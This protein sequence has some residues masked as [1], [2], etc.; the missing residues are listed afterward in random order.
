MEHA[1]SNCGTLFVLGDGTLP[2]CRSCIRSRFRHPKGIKPE[3][4]PCGAVGSKGFKSYIGD[5][6]DADQLLDYMASGSHTSPSGCQVFISKTHGSFN[7]VSYLPL[8]QIPGSGYKAGHHFAAHFAILMDLQGKSADGP[9]WSFEEEAHLQ[10][11]ITKGDFV[12]A[13]RCA[14]CRTVVVYAPEI[15][16]LN[17]R[18]KIA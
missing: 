7:A 9:H 1:C 12:P 11:R 2:E 10:L 6:V 5:G 15:I 4:T 8:G 3:H 17:C 13:P 14:S 18:S 16:C